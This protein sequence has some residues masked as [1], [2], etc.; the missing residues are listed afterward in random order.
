MTVPISNPVHIPV[1]TAEVLRALELQPGQ[2]YVDLTA[3]LGGH[4][5]QAAACVGPAGRIVLND[6]D[7]SNL[8]RAEAAVRGVAWGAPNPG[9]TVTFRGNFAEVPHRLAQSGIRADAVFADLGFSS[10]QMDDGSRGFSFMRDGPLDMRLDPSGGLTAADLVNHATEAELMGW[11]REFGEDPHAPRIARKLVQARSGGPILSTSR[12][13]EVVRSAIPGNRHTGI[14]P[15]TRT[16]Q[17]IR[18]VVND[19]L[20]SLGALLAAVER[21]DRSGWLADRARVAVLTFHS[22]EDRMVKRAFADLVDRGIATAPGGQPVA[23]G[24]VESGRNPRARSA[25]L[26]WI[27]LV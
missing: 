8:T 19:E 20:G 10:N 3:G 2:T 25:K 13:A 16:F 26:R 17:A 22:L 14:D 4:A 1:M 21:G 6:L 23:T 9:A 7:A 12:F 27:K 18:I 11:I 24:E 5:G 15:A